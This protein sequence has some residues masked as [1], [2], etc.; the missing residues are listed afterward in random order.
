MC[1]NYFDCLVYPYLDLIGKAVCDCLLDK[2]FD[3]KLHGGRAIDCIG[4]AM[5]QFLQESGE[6]N[7]VYF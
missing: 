1:R 2:N 7:H 4:Q 3:L 5:C 6:K